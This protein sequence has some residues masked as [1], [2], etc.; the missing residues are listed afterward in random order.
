MLAVFIIL[1]TSPI[2]C[3]VT[4]RLCKL[5]DQKEEDGE[6]AVDPFFIDCHERERERERTKR[7]NRNRRGEKKDENERNVS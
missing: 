1:P 6:V 5:R 7:C 3:S 4:A 2:Q